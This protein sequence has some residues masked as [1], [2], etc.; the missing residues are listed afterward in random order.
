MLSLY[1]GTIPPSLVLFF[2]ISYKQ[3][4]CQYFQGKKRAHHEIEEVTNT[5]CLHKWLG[6]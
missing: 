1:G 5:R 4:A 2:Y 6:K 3:K